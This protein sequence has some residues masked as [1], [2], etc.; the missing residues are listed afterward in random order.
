MPEKKVSIVVPTI[1]EEKVLPDLFENLSALSPQP[2]EIIF[3]DGPSKD[4]TANLI[5]ERGFHLIRSV[6]KGRS[7]Q[8]NEGAF[9]STGDYLVFL[10]ADTAVP[11]DIVQIVEKNLANDHVTLGGFT[12]IFKGRSFFS[13]HNRLFAFLGGLYYNPIRCICFGFRLL[14]GDQVMFC[15]KADFVKVGGFNEELPMMED[16]DLC[17]RLNKLGCIKQIKERVF[18]S[19]RRIARL[20]TVKTYMRFAKLYLYYR[21]GVSTRWVKAQFEEIR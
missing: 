17:L 2:H 20:G 4:E 16:A 5:T 7:L 15:R 12:S 3:V 1:N 8:L 14:N 13:L 21:F 10:H 18:T 19:D 9:Q 6:G 11:S